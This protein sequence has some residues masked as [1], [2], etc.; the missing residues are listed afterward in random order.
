MEKLSALRPQD[1]V[2]V[3]A[4]AAREPYPWQSN[5]MAQALYLSPAEVSYALRR[6]QNSRLLDAGKR[7]LRRSVVEFL[8]HGLP[9]VFPAHPGFQARG[10]CTGPSVPFLQQQFGE[11]ISYVW[12]VAEGEAWGAA[13]TP[14]Y[15]GAPEAAKHDPRLYELL[16]LVDTIR[17]GRPREVKLAGDLLQQRLTALPQQAHDS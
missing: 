2:L 15:P 10:M 14:L 7:V 8:R 4:L 9:Y 1:V 5:Q 13:I 3:L 17:L 16:A 11:G 12:P 6:C